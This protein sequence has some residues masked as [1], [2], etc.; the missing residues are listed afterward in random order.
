MAESKDNKLNSEK[1]M[2]LS[3]YVDDLKE[4][5][6]SNYVGSRYTNNK[7]IYKNW[8]EREI[9]LHETKLQNLKG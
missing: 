4:K 9:K 1:V 8:L 6:K 7:E 2:R 5:L 3:K